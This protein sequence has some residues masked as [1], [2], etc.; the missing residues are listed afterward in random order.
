MK[1]VVHAVH[2]GVVTGCLAVAAGLQQHGRRYYIV[3]SLG[4]V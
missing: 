1:V 4:N 3:R 2:V